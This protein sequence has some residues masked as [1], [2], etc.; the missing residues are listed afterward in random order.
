M[1]WYNLFFVYVGSGKRLRL[2]PESP[3]NA[4]KL[5]TQTTVGFINSQVQLRSIKLSPTSYNLIEFGTN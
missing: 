3:C 4:K 1:R 5:K 2:L